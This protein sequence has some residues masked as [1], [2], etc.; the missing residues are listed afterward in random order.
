MTSE[1]WYPF[2]GRPNYEISDEGGL[3]TIDGELV[4]LSV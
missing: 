1:T 4:P 3:R 2:P